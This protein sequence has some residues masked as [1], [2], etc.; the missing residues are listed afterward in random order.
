MV[1]IKLE[2]HISSLQGKLHLL[3]LGTKPIAP[4]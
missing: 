1:H 4:W 3:Q 2:S